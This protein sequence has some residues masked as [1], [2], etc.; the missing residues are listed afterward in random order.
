MKILTDRHHHGLLE[1]LHL[2]FEDRFD[3]EVYVPFGMQWFDREYWNFE[4]EWHHDAVARQYLVGV[5]EGA[6]A[7]DGVVRQPDPRQPD[8]MVKGIKLDAALTTDWDIVLTSLPHNYDGY[9][10][11]A[12]ET[13]A[14]YAIQIGNNVQTWDP[15]AD[16]ALASSTL[17]GFG[18]EWVTKTFEY[19]GV[20][21]VMYHQEFRL[22]DFRYEWPQ[23]GPNNVIASFVNCF[24]EGPSY[25]AFAS[26]ARAV[27][28]FDWRVYGAYGTGAPD[29]FKAGDI[30]T[31]AG[32]A[33]AMRAARVGW[34]SKHWSDGFGH[35][36]HN[37]AAV[38]R[39]VIG[40]PR[41]Y[42]D[43]LAGPLFVEGVTSFD[44]ESRDAFELATLLRRLRDDDDYH[45]RISQD[46]FVRFTQ[47]VDFDADA[48]AV[49]DLLGRVL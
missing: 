36:I 15:R 11:L 21:T 12:Q 3:I 41:Y 23:A 35:V 22:S 18:P 49:Y 13:G 39:P 1:S 6:D 33:D 17:P 47:V 8:R 42:R 20:P 5:W 4:R 7:H 43:K 2:L 30:G 29:E 16:F 31:T 37:W 40:I 28:E 14:K 27:P 9:Y 25:P 45:H 32:V 44:L 48:E 46:M 34:H 38:G 19:E 10:R 24:P 26:F